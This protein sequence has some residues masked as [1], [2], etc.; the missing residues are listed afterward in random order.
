MIGRGKQ[1]SDLT[2]R[3]PNISRQHAAIEYSGGSFWMVDLGSTNG[4]E[5]NGQRVQRKQIQNGDVYKICSH[6]LFMTL[7]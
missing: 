3:D 7:A 4:V 2:I 1:A 5:F 6:E